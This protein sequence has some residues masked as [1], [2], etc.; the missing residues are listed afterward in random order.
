MSIHFAAPLNGPQKEAVT[1]VDG[2]LLILAGA[3]SGKTRVITYRTAYLLAKGVSPENILC[4]TFTNKAAREM[5]ERIA[6]EVGD[7][8]C[9]GLTVSTF[10]AFCL[11]VLKREIMRLGYSGKF[12]VCDSSDQEQL[13]FEILRELG[14]DIKEVPLYD[15][16]SRISFAKNQLIA[17]EVYEGTDAIGKMVKIIYPRYQFFLKQISALDFDDL[18]YMTAT[19]FRDHPAALPRYQKKFKYLMVDEYQDTNLAQYTLIRQ[20][21]AHGNV[22]VVGDDDQSIY[23]WRGANVENIHRFTKDFEN[24]KIV[25]LEENYRSTQTILSAANAVIQNNQDRTGKNLF[26][27]LGKGEVLRTIG[28]ENPYEEAEKVGEAMQLMRFKENIPWR[29]FAVLYRTHTQSRPVEE[30]FARLHIPYQVSGRIDFYDRK[31]VKDAVAYLKLIHNPEDDLAYLRIVN[32]PR[33]GIGSNTLSHIKA[34]AVEKQISF[35]EATRQYAGNASVKKDLSR[36]MLDFTQTV[37]DYNGK[38]VGAVFADQAAAFFE[39]IGFVKEIEREAVDLKIREKKI[40]N[41]AM[42]LDSLKGYAKK[43]KNP[44]LGDYLLKL[45]LFFTDQNEPNE[46][47][48]LSENAVHLLTIHASKGLEFPHVTIIGF[49]ENMIPFVREEMAVATPEA[50]VEKEKRVSEERRLCYVAMTRAQ[51]TLTLSYSAS[52]R[53]REGNLIT[54]PSRFLS[55]IPPELIERSEGVDHIFKTDLSG[56]K[57]KDLADL[58]LQK[59]RELFNKPADT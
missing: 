46:A 55:E 59:M 35:H 48:D 14:M 43:A 2:P 3:G 29:N 38:M 11:R 22:V 9:E 13:Y 31:E 36:E 10:H 8:A 23:S 1:H 41:L 39:A 32:F 20:L 30:T 5:K 26:S 25:K 47:E 4:V 33:R 16:R 21:G 19:L 28:A 7:T 40:S 53:K 51:K 6:S 15:I 17:P 27:K 52:R 42:F 34:L 24:V 49:E 54:Q 37:S 56:D 57:P 58:S 45:T 50:L 18:L 44:S 12:T